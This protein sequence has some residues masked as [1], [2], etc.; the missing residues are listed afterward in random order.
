M[1]LKIS[2]LGKWFG[3]DG[4]K[5][6]VFSNFN[7]QIDDGEFVVL[8]GRSGVG[9]TTLLRMIAGLDLPDEG[10]IEYSDAASRSFICTP[11][12]QSMTSVATMVFQE[13]E[14]SLL[15][16]QKADKAVNWAYHGPQDQRVSTVEKL[17]EQMQFNQD[18]LSQ[19]LPAMMSG[20]QKQRVAIARA[21]AKHPQVFLLD[22]PFGSLDA[23]WR[24][25]L[26][27]LLRNVWQSREPRPMT[28]VVTH[29][30]EEAVY[31]ANRVLVLGGRPA[32]V[33][34]DIG[35]SSPPIDRGNPA[36]RETTDFTHY[37]ATI[38][39]ALQ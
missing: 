22:E 34:G 28:I 2:G 33:C 27:E 18:H 38:R 9:K 8:V 1:P 35:L 7:L 15:P 36:V 10:S 23:S 4:Q 6:H 13:Y 32:T 21:L 31:L 14:R 39:Q 12:A 19:R 17:M 5:L 25:S 3:V 11:H 24:Y 26:E 30:I 29:D 37:R 20:G 16:W